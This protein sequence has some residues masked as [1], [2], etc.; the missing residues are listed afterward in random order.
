M[1]EN[2]NFGPRST[3]SNLEVLPLSNVSTGAGDVAGQHHAV[4]QLIERRRLAP[5]IVS[6]GSDDVIPVRFGLSE[7]LAE[8]LRRLSPL[9]FISATEY[10]EA[11]TDPLH[12][13][14]GHP[15]GYVGYE[16]P[17]GLF[18]ATKGGGTDSVHFIDF[19]GVD[20]GKHK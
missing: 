17:G 19:D 12:R 13:L 6:I 1:T 18:D 15:A 5:G 14:Y 16:E 9:V 10:S 3:R 20:E 11:D 7:A 8:E 2:S 4:L